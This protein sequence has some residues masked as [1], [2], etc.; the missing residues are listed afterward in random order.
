MA[1]ARTNSRNPKAVEHHPG[2]VLLAVRGFVVIAVLAM[3]AGSGLWLHSW[4]TDPHTLPIRAVQIEGTFRHLSANQLQRSL[5]NLV[6]GGFFSINIGA[7][8][9]VLLRQPWVDK[10]SVRRVWPGTLR[11]RVSEQVPLARWGDKGLVNKRGDWFAAPQD[12][13]TAALPEFSGPDGFQDVLT[14]SY[15]RFNSDLH[16]LGLK[17]VGLHVNERRAWNLQLSNGIE[18][19]LGRRDIEQRI[20]R[21]VR[22]YRIVKAQRAEPIA[23]VDLRYTNGFAV[24]WKAN[25]APAQTGARGS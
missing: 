8:R 7:I 2:R 4:L 1:R 20:E 6:R 22:T 14:A 5:G 12:K 13:S 18:L 24:R 21:F 11:I 3:L 17:V 15:Y 19:R 9:Q 10:V 25:A 16:P 23:A